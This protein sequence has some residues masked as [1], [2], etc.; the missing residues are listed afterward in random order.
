VDLAKRA[1]H[2]G[3]FAAGE[4][5]EC[6]RCWQRNISGAAIAL[7]AGMLAGVR[8]IVIVSSAAEGA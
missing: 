1:R 3:S 5:K 6:G 7:S 8:Q 4:L 2:A